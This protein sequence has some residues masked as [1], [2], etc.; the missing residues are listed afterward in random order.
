MAYLMQGTSGNPYHAWAGMQACSENFQSDVRAVEILKCKSPEKHFSNIDS[1]R[2]LKSPPTEGVIFLNGKQRHLHGLQ[3]HQTFASKL[4][5]ILNLKISFSAFLT[6][7]RH[8]VL[9][10]DNFCHG[11]KVND[12][13]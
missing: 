3:H 8:K 12:I 2:I 10:M 7:P 4:L 11:I 6:L 1:E 9:L 13:L 5:P